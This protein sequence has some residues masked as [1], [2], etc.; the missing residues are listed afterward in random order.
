VSIALENFAII[1]LRYCLIRVRTEAMRSIPQP[2]SDV[3]LHT[4]HSV[5][6]RH[7]RGSSLLL[8]G[9][10][11]SMASNA[12][13]QV[14]IIRYLTK[15][16]YGALALAL[17]VVNIG[18]LVVSLSLDKAVSRFV[19]I[20]HE[21]KDYNRLFGTIILVVSTILSLGILLTLTVI[22]FQG[23]I[24]HTLI[25][26]PLAI[27]L[28][29]FLIV[30]SPVQ[31]IDEVL[32]S[33]FAIFTGPRAIF[34]RRHVAAPGLRMSVVLILILLHGDVFFLAT[35]YLITSI[36]VIP[37]YALILFKSLRK[38]GLFLQ[39]DPRKIVFPV[40]A[41]FAF[42]I[43]LLTTDL[44]YVL[45]ESMDAVLLG[46]YRGTSDIATFRSVQTAAGLNQLAMMSFQT[47]F[48]PL[49]AR[50]FA[51]K[52]YEGINDLY[53]QTSIWMAVISFPVFAA[54]FAL[55]QPITVLVYGKSYESAA[56]ILALLSLGYYFNTA[57]GFN[58]LT[59]R[60]FGKVRFILVI[61]I[62][63]IIVN[64]GI[65]LLLIPRYGALGAAYG[66][67]GTMIIHNLLKQLGLRLST[68]VKFFERRHT[69]IYL[70]IAL[71]SVGLFLIQ[72]LTSVH[73][74]VT[75]V[76]VI[77]ASLFVVGLNRK[78]LK[79]EQTFPELLRFTLIRR[80]FGD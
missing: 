53:W 40:G 7:I 42:T 18:Q 41:I 77:L 4:D 80:F 37:V 72:Q 30:L 67:C 19:P 43:P 74:Y 6:N 61:N 52:N 58:G 9:R 63:A 69:K 44:L 79:V 48:T 1:V 66:T 59:I 60:V 16:E 71:T 64:L 5:P 56:P 38:Q 11:F 68:S 65:N 70:S 54:T 21:Q 34:F 15:P 46:Y 26:D 25:N 51:K 2:Q 23:L 28:L 20:Y 31:A 76:L 24:A 45:M 8:V 55:A 75:L 3:A 49:A 22:S 29:V 10:A 14:F 50:M 62:L 13:I 17:S 12:L 39:F 73:I 78:S 35:G 27:S 33:L 47:L 32:V 36:V 57:L